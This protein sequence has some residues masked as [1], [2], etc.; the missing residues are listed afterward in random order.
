MGECMLEGA[1]DG[2]EGGEAVSVDVRVECVG[3]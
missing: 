1:V 3:W 2:K